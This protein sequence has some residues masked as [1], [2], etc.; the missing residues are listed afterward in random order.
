MPSGFMYLLA[1][2]DVYSRYIIGWAPSNTL[3]Q[4]IVTEVI[5][6]ETQPDRIKD[7]LINEFRDY[8]HNFLGEYELK[9]FAA[10]IND[11]SSEMIA[12][13]YGFILKKYSTIRIEFLLVKNEHRRKGLGKMLLTQLEK[14]AI[15]QNCTQIQVSTMEFQG[16]S[17]YEKM[18]YNRIGVIPKWFC[19]KDEIFFLKKL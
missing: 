2:I 7:L 9:K 4:K 17:F 11:D 12:G 19:N 16:P 1:L 15:S 18:G 5:I 8:N 3:E 14:Y 10:Y 13:L 6:D